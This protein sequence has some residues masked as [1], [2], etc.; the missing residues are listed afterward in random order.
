MMKCFEA[1]K[2]MVLKILNATGNWGILLNEKKI[3]LKS[4]ILSMI[5]IKHM[6]KDLYHV[7]AIYVYEWVRFLVVCELNFSSSYFFFCFFFLFRAA[8]MAYESSHTRGWIRA[9]AAG[10]RH[11][12]SSTISKTCLWPT[13]QLMATPD[14]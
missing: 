9:V 1:I 3:K 12:H 6:Y 5:N 10:L 7:Y 11:I 13:L 2:I 4:Y 14:P 8:H